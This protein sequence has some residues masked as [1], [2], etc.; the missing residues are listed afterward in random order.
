MGVVLWPPLKRRQ[1]AR[2]GCTCE[3]TV[4][5]HLMLFFAYVIRIHHKGAD[6]ARRTHRVNQWRIVLHEALIKPC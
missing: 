5:V 2:L 3:A 1:C 6:C 4:V